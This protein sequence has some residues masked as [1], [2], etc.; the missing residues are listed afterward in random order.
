[1]PPSIINLNKHIGII[2]SI[3]WL[4]NPEY[5]TFSSKS[6]SEKDIKWCLLLPPYHFLQSSCLFSAA[7]KCIPFQT[8]PSFLPQQIVYSKSWLF[9]ISPVSL[10]TY[11]FLMV[12]SIP[13]APRKYHPCFSSFIYPN[14][15]STYSKS[16]MELVT[17]TDRWI[18]LKQCYPWSF[19]MSCILLILVQTI[20]GKDFSKRGYHHGLEK[21]SKD[22]KR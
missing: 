6:S 21:F 7:V 1:M 3:F 13:P 20:T 5:C 8:P 16:G 11:Y 18:R 9:H 10:L 4:R 22:S 14:I 2:I 17:R 12:P 15:M 19:L